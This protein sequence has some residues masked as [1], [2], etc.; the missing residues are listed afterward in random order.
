MPNPPATILWVMREVFL[1]DDSTDLR[2]M[3]PSCALLDVCPCCHAVEL[4]LGSPPAPHPTRNTV[5]KLYA[6]AA[7]DRREA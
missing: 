7:V 5:M 3:A 1:E 4:Q 6:R 2:G